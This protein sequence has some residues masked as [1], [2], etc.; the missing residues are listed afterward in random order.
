MKKLKRLYVVI[1]VF[2][3]TVTLLNSCSKDFNSE[4]CI[5]RSKLMVYNTDEEMLI[6]EFME[7]IKL[8]KETKKD[9]ENFDL[10]SRN[11][12]MEINE[13]YIPS[14]KFDEYK[15]FLISVS[16]NSISYTYAP[17]E[18]VE[19]ST[20]FPF[21]TSSEISIAIGRREK[22]DK[23]DPMERWIDENTILT[24]EGY[25]YEKNDITGLMDIIW[26]F[27][28]TWMRIRSYSAELPYDYNYIVD[29]I[30]IELI[31]VK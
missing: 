1:T 6:K 9:D 27:D 20:E 29:S 7:Q 21:E 11:N 17:K 10:Y 3:L 25:I 28:N 18:E 30:S 15:L 26:P 31:T 24:K 12:I 13:F 16:K 8:S 23:Y 14:I 19:N 22:D 2:I 4:E 5:K